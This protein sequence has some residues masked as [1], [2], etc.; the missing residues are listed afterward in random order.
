MYLLIIENVNN[1]RIIVLNYPNKM[2]PCNK[3]EY[4]FNSL[5]FCLH[6]GNTILEHY[7]CQKSFRDIKYIYIF[8]DSEWSKSLEFTIMFIYL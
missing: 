5:F 7:F 4:I 3:K 8:M 6:L 2:S 1:L